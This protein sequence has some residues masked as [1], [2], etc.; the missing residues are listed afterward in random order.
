MILEKQTEAD[1]LVEG[2]MSD[3]IA[4]GLDLD[5]AQMIM[6]MLS[7]NLYSDEIGSPIRELA[8]NALDSHRRAGV[9]KPIV[10]SLIRNE[11]YNYE[12]SVED[13]GIGLDADDIK[14]IISK[15]G[16]SLARTEANALGMMGL[17]F[18]SPL[19]YT[20]AF[21]FICRKDGMERKYMMY[22]GENGN[23]IDPLSEQETDQPNGVKVIMPI[24][25]GDRYSFVTKIKEQLAYFESVFFN[26]DGYVS[27]DYNIHRSE[28]FQFSDMSQDQSMHICLDNVYYPLD[29]IK[30]GID[31]INVPIGLRFTLTDGLF[32]VPNREAL[33]YTPE[34]KQTIL[35]KIHQVADYFVDKYNEQVVYTDDINSIFQY[36]DTK[37]RHVVIEGRYYDIATLMPFT[38]KSVSIPTY[39]GM[40]YID[41]K[42]V[43]NHKAHL[44]KEY[45][46]N[47]VYRN[48]K[49]T[50]INEAVK[51]NNV[52]NIHYYLFTDKVSGN[53]R[54][55]MKSIYA[56]NSYF[57]K[58]TRPFVLGNRHST[59]TD[60]YHVLLSLHKYPKHL[61]RKIIV[62]YQTLQQIYISQFKDYDAIEIPKSWHD[63]RKKKRIYTGGGRRTKLKGQIFGK[64]CTRLEKQVRDKSSKLVPI[65]LDLEDLHKFKGLTVYTSYDDADLLDPLYKITNRVK[66]NLR[67]VA[68]SDREMKLV[69]TLDIHNL[70][71]YDKFMEGNNM[72]FKRLITAYLIAGLIDEQK[73][74][75]SKLSHI[76]TVSTTLYNKLKEL[77]DYKRDHYNNSSDSIFRA[78]LEVAQ[79]HQLFDPSIYSTYLSIKELLDKLKFLN[80]V[81]KQSIENGYSY[82][83][84]YFDAEETH[85]LL[86]DMFKYHKQ[87]VNLDNY[88]ISMNPDPIVLDTIVEDEEDL[89]E[90][91]DLEE[92]EALTDEVLQ[93]LQ[94][95]AV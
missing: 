15:Y 17:G 73:H 90:Q 67:Y 52:D 94:E 89:P 35:N 68:F 50:E 2:E 83:S 58:K 55:Y 80:I 30:M 66:I 77:K 10:V 87:R 42:N 74:V 49:V 60:N 84:T 28:H 85:Q 82:R 25:S 53:K 36:Y 46:A 64:I 81:L 8:S 19:A 39:K 57:V 37:V 76:E 70:I 6:Q 86:V 43:F 44:L 71:S 59:N 88:K 91:D 47:Y 20:S 33:R 48:G 92:D 63:D 38:T 41:M 72:P 61:W 11:Q 18:K 21:Y 54:E 5:S 27:N 13:F 29:F 1:V 31:R 69:K 51:A 62:E 14:N 4:M 65:T 7:K 78:M 93:E 56:S 40:K 16:K 34:A 75:F 95:Q 24:K 22:E 12:F 26:C 32:P 23:S 79:E 9:D 3:T 45:R